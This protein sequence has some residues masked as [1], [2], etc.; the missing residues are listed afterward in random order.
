MSEYPIIYSINRRAYVAY[1]V[2]IDEERMSVNDQFRMFQD[3]LCVLNSRLKTSNLCYN[4]LKCALLPPDN[5]KGEFVF[6]FDEGLQSVTA[7]YIMDSFKF[8]VP[9]LKELNKF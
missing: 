4:D 2:I 1:D 5:N 3:S 8:I 6:I 9:L 7:N